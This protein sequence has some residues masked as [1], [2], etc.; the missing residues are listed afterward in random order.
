[1]TQVRSVGQK[2][3][4]TEKQVEMIE[5]LLLED[6]RLLAARDLALFRVGM[7]TMLR[8]SDLLMIKVGQVSYQ[9]EVVEEFAIRMQK[10]G[11]PIECQLLP[12]AQKALARW[13]LLSGIEGDD[14]FVFPITRRHYS[15]IVKG[16][17][18]MLR[19]NPAKYSTHSLRRTRPAIIYAKTK[20]ME[21]V[22]QLLGH[23]GLQA[24]SAYL[25]V[26]KAK[27]FAVSKDFDI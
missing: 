25:G 18:K 17:A 8:A 11:R 21:V 2:T 20:N 5:A 26:D 16:F 12:K 24:T 23:A 1:M 7:S 10:T 15:R 9:G 3:P 13:L 19:L 22:R 14:E 27:A 6:T 4:F